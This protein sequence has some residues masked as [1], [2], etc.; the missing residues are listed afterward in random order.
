MINKNLD[1]QSTIAKTLFE[2][3]MKNWDVDTWI[4]DLL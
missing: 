2:L 3:R 4:T 1:L